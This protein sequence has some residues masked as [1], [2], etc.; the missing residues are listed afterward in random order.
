MIRFIS[1]KGSN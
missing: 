1:E